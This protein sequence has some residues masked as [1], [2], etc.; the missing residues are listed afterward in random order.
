MPETDQGILDILHAEDN[1]TD[2]ERVRA[3]LEEAGLP[4]NVTV[5]KS[6]R[7]FTSSVKSK[8]FDL[9]MSD[10]A[11][12]SL[13]GKEAF[14]IASEHAPE[15]PFIFVS[16]TPGEDTAIQCL[17]EGATD[18]VLKTK[19]GRLVPAVRR[20]VREADEKRRRKLAEKLREMALDD[21]KSSEARF[22]GV[23]EC[24]PDAA[25]LVDSNGRITFA[26]TRAEM[27]FG[28]KAEKL[29]G[30]QL[31]DLV[32]EK[33]K[34]L[35]EAHVG[36]YIGQPHSRAL[37]TGVELYAKRSDGTEF[38]ADI[39]LSPLKTDDEVSVLAMIRDITESRR[40]ESALRDSEEQF[41]GIYENSPVSIFNVNTDGHIFRCNQATTA[42][43][44]YSVAELQSMHFNDFTHPEDRE[45]G[46]H[47][48]KQLL[49]GTIDL[50]KIEKR[51]VT[52]SGE[53]IRAHLTVSAVRNKDRS[54][55]YL[56]SILQ[57]TTQWWQAQ[58]L[59]RRSEEQYR[60]LV[61]NARDAIYTLSSDGILLTLNPAFEILTG[62]KREEWLGK[63]FADL[64]HPDERTRA[65]NSFS[66]T[67]A[68]EMVEVVQYRVLRKSGDY[69]VGEF[70]TTKLV[71]E[72][73][74]AGVLGIARDVT[75]LITMEEQLRQSQ[76]MESIGTLAGGIAHDFNNILG[77]IVGYASLIL[78]SAGE[79][80]RLERNIQSI[81][82]AAQRGVSL[83]RQ[84][85]MFARKQERLLQTVDIN[86]LVIDIYRMI[87]E[88]F[89]K[90]VSVKLKQGK[91]DLVVY[92]D[93]TEIHQ[94]VLNL[95]VNAR[96]AM[97]ERT[98]GKL[99]GGILTIATSSV[100]GKT[101]NARHTGGTSDE[102]VRIAVSDT[103]IGM[104][105]ATRARIFEPFFTTKE[106]GK[107]TGLGLS[108]VYGIVSAQNG[109]IE[110]STEP[111]VGRTFAVLLPLCKPTDS[112]L[113]ATSKQ[114]AESLEGNETILVVED[115]A[116]LRDLL[117]DIL[118]SRGY[119]VLSAE[120]GQRALAL[121]LDYKDINL[122]VSDIGLPNVGGLDLFQTVKKL[123][124]EVKVILVSGFVDEA[125]KQAMM[126]R[127]VD[128]F[129]Q[130][131]YQPL[132]VLTKVREVLDDR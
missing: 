58:E 41:R 124:P 132:E 55:R 2:A 72:D 52:K 44:G 32:P 77:I 70:N 78:R 128:R 26:N 111:G 89:P 16:G 40:A 98:D 13:D 100:E 1:L 130:K 33:F 17:I 59:L 94:A 90:A 82:S 61:D 67:L 75:S 116:G 23:L 65:V 131:P 118:T 86:D 6:R 24:A 108:T 30:K 93:Q 15:T 48:M 103:G 43:L 19:M 35:H 73:G 21:L 81:Q 122:V 104:D 117:F 127:G 38:P 9:I 36:R 54:I 115:E 119:K 106:R 69:A 34:Q 120:D 114:S 68:G 113:A 91:E 28:F 60:S 50:V 88:T 99:P 129:I 102:Y 8:K 76:K 105:E 80:E 121:F 64:I 49:S 3:M 83:V 5:V 126:D 97:I 42:L 12:P 20:A 7:D 74:T 56:I 57:D 112:N 25:I 63:R 79:D 101:V 125:E 66:R 51:Y 18:Y 14:L 62:W 46:L 39:M 109:Y 29:M 92:G 47:V 27:M 123:K 85:L 53:T 110:L 96:D 84:L 45:I 10:Y 37:G 87:S 4:C 11:L 71:L 31:G 22:R 95:C 107:G